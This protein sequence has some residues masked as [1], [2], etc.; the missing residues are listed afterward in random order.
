[1]DTEQ[2]PDIGR[3]AGEKIR[4]RTIA[5]LDGRT[6]AAKRA[7]EMVRELEQDMGG[8]P[9]TAQRALIVRAAILT[10]FVADCEAAYLAGSMP[11]AA[12]LPAVDRL[13]RLLE[14]IGLERKAKDVT[15]L[16]SYIASKGR[17]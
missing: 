4:L 12:W 5:D 16:R 15:S 6:N 9:S 14:S 8:D 7:R 10:S 11:D 13:R 1:M 3:K 17:S 2:P